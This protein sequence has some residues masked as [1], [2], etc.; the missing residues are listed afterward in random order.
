MHFSLVRVVPAVEALFVRTGL[1]AFAVTATAL[2][3]DEH[4]AVF[5][6]LV[7]GIARAGSEAGGIGA[8][9]TDSRQVEEPGLVLRQGFSAFEV[10]ALDPFL[11]AD[12]MVLVAV[13]GGPFFVGRQVAQG[14]LGA[15]G[16]DVDL[17][18]FEDGL[19]VEF[20][21]RAFLAFS[22]V[23]PG[24]AARVGALQQIENLNVPMMRIAA[25]GLGFDVVPPHVFLAAREGP[26][27]LAGHGAALA[28]DAAVEVEDKGELVVGISRFIREIHV[29]AQLPIEDV[30]HVCSG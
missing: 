21:V 2:L 30:A 17:G 3:V 29:A 9:I 18:R 15:L 26:G 7:N 28:A 8:V 16:T 14:F 23:V 4:D 1:Q 19:A 22:F 10:L 24:L 5:G 6:A 20:A 11:G 13:G 12:R 25:V 27:G